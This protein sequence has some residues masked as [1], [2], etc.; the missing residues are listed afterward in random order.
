MCRGR[1][2]VQQ[3]DQDSERGPGLV[4]YAMWKLDTK[5]VA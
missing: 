5:S 3:H 2:Q 1:G 4:E